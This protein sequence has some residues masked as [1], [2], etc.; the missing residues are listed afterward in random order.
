MF[1]TFSYPKAPEKSF[2]GN[3]AFTTRTAQKT[4]HRPENDFI[5]RLIPC[6]LHYKERTLTDP[7]MVYFHVS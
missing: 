7:S 3:I 1:R 6:T 2:T 4:S 5:H